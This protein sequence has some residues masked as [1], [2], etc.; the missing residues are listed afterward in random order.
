[1][2]SSALICAG[3]RP[4]GRPGATPAQNKKD[5][6]AATVALRHQILFRLVKARPAAMRMPCRSS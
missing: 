3:S 1:L 6:A 2:I 5:T 4:A